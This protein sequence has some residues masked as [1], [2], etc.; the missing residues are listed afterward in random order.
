MQLL[1]F[2]PSLSLDHK[3]YSFY[4]YGIHFNTPNLTDKVQKNHYIISNK[5]SIN[6]DKNTHNEQVCKQQ[7]INW[8][9]SSTR[10]GA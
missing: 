6:K 9:Q 2:Y 4:Y 5:T 7:E 10:K 3:I 8:L 1:T